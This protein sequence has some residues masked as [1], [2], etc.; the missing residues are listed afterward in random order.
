MTD[1]NIAFQLTLGHEGG[2]SDNSVDPGGLT[3]KGISQINF[4]GWEGWDIVEAVMKNSTIENA[5]K[6]LDTSI[7]LQSKVKDFYLAH[8]WIGTNIQAIP[9]QALANTLFDIA[10]NNG[11]S[12]SISYLQKSLQLLATISS[13]SKISIDGV[14][15]S[16]T[17]SV[18][19]SYLDSYKTHVGRSPLLNEQVII[20]VIHYFQVQKYVGIVQANADE[21]VFLYGWLV[22]V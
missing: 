4:P 8:F 17:L 13:A 20:K 3:Y 1:F 21:E 9:T 18:L 15:G 11:A 16:N 22:R 19:Q 14:L 2:L 7:V 12:T 5:T 6:Y 10:V